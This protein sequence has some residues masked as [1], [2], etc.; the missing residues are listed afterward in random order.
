[1]GLPP[2][3]ASS[4]EHGLAGGC[5]ASISAGF[6]EA[7]PV[8]LPR[9]AA[10]ASLWLWTLTWAAWAAFD[11]A[12]PVA[13]L[14]PKLVISLWRFGGLSGPNRSWDE[15]EVGMKKM[16]LVLLFVIF[17]IGIGAWSPCS[18][19]VRSSPVAPS[20]RIP[21]LLAIPCRA[22]LPHFFPPIFFAQDH[23]LWL[24]TTRMKLW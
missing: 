12:H 24:S 20:F 13:D 1:M 17:R 9:R 19:I 11:P 21:L 7:A 14:E 3:P 18:P 22:A 23:T 16:E 15:E 5:S 6:V 8:L 2:H 4:P 10:D